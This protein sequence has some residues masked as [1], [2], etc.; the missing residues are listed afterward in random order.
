MEGQFSLIFLEEKK[1]YKVF[2]DKSAKKNKRNNSYIVS[3][4][5]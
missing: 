2:I 4:G 1:K 5:S 3:S